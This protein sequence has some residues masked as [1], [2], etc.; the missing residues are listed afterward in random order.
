MPFVQYGQVS[1]NPYIAGA[2]EALVGDA[3]TSLVIRRWRKRSP[4]RRAFALSGSLVARIASRP[5]RVKAGHAHVAGRGRRASSATDGPPCRG[6]RASGTRCRLRGRRSSG[7]DRGSSSASWWS[8]TIVMAAR[9][10]EQERRGSV[11][12]IATVGDA[13]DGRSGAGLAGAPRHRERCRTSR[14]R[15]LDGADGRPARRLL[16]D[17]AA[18][19]EV[20]VGAVT[21]PSTRTGARRAAGWCR[22]PT[23]EGCRGA[24]RS[25]LLR[26]PSVEVD[27]DPAVA[28]QRQLRYGEERQW[29][30]GAAHRARA[31]RSWCSW[32]RESHKEIAGTSVISE[33][34]VRT[35]VNSN[36]RQAR[37][38][39]PEPRRRGGRCARGSPR[40]RVDRVRGPAPGCLHCERAIVD[41]RSR[42]CASAREPESARWWR[43]RALSGRDRRRT[44]DRRRVRQ[45]GGM[46]DHGHTAG[47]V[48]ARLICSFPRREHQ[49][50]LEYFAEQ[51]AGTTGRGPPRR[52]APMA[53]EA[54]SGGRA[55][56]STSGRLHGAAV[57]R[58]VTT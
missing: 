27:R 53:R 3:I 9:G 29:T 17:Q 56:H 40:S 38:E 8:M 2:Q 5:R 54:R 46:S 57:F 43:G 23:G 33:C 49:A 37:P 6:P 24:T 4:A 48:R 50:M 47:R 32:R 15:T 16:G 39:P 55:C 20:Q 35:H 41:E 34:T 30:R 19:T 13:S 28:R 44:A 1:L 22:G 26:P 36:P 18:L 12:D 7:D 51:L 52:C 31:Q 11:D 58:D 25:P 42:A 21:S 45:S 10:A 14:R